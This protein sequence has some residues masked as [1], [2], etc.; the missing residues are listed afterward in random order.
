MRRTWDRSRVISVLAAIKD[1]GISV[2]KMTRMAR[3][4][5]STIY[6]WM[7]GEV[8][9][10]Y[11]LVHNLAYALWPRQ[12]DLARE[13]VEASGYA[14]VEPDAAPEPPRI[15][16]DV[17]DVIQKNYPASKQAEIIEM[18]EELSGNDALPGSEAPPGASGTTRAG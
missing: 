7:G 9:P 12:P 11:D 16:R 2:P 8:A 18:L 4:N 17:L 1:T 10:D 13:L 5:R 6:R 14:W 3:A 15:P